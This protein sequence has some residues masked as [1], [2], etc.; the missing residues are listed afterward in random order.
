M[1]PTLNF[2]SFEGGPNDKH[3]MLPAHFLMNWNINIIAL[4]CCVHFCSTTKWTNYTYTYIPSFT[5]LPPTHRH[6]TPLGHHGA[7]SW[8]QPPACFKTHGLIYMSMLLSQIVPPSPW[9]YVGMSNLCLCL[10]S[11]LRNR[12]IC[13]IFLNSTYLDNRWET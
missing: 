11:C 5:D 8:A 13:T 12:F 7:L 4:R 9:P 10:Y 3:W 6:P 1:G 2:A